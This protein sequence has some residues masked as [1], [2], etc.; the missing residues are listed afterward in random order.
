[1]ARNQEEQYPEGHFVG[2]W[3][4]IGIALFSGLGIPLAIATG[5]H[6]LMGI[7]PGLGVAFGV[8]VGQGIENRYKKEGRIRPLTP[9]EKKKK[10]TVLLIGVAMLALGAAAFLVLLLLRKG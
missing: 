3:L 1:M 7:G 2:M 9:A 10:K 5:N 8:A 6:G 4:G